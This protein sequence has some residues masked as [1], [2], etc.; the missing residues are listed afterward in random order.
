MRQVPLEWE[1]VLTEGI[2]G[3]DYASLGAER[4][5]VELVM[6]LVVGSAIVTVVVGVVAWLAP[7]IARAVP[8]V[9]RL[10]RVTGGLSPMV[11]VLV[12]VHLCD[13]SL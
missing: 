2:E 6:L 3:A 9:E 7:S 4:I 11:A 10:V 13:G 12:A 5:L 8:R 1:A